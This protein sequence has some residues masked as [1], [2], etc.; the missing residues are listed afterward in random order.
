MQH[1]SDVYKGFTFIVEKKISFFQI[2]KK[3][4]TKKIEKSYNSCAYTT[5]I[6]HEKI[7]NNVAIQI[8]T[9]IGPLAYLPISQSQTS[10]VY[11]IHEH[12]KIGREKIVNLIKQYNP[13]YKIKKIKCN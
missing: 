13:K 11:S 4:F 7:S 1:F 10:V 3:Y 5:V 12:K 6:Y 9:K 2:I 8:F